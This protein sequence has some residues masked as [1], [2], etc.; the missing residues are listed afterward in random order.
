MRKRGYAIGYPFTLKVLRCVFRWST[1]SGVGILLLCLPFRNGPIYEI[2]AMKPYATP[3]L[4]LF[5]IAF[6]FCGTSYAVSVYQGFEYSVLEGDVTIEGYIFTEPET[7]ITIPQAIEGLPVTAIASN[8]FAS[9]FNLVAI[10][11]PEGVKS[12]GP[13]SFDFCKYLAEI[14]I[15]QTVTAIGNGAFAFCER[16]ESVSLP[17]GLT[18]IEVGLFDYCLRLQTVTVPEGVISIGNWAFAACQSL[19]TLTIPAAVTSI[20]N[21]AFIECPSLTS[22][23]F[24]G[25][26]PALGVDVFKDTSVQLKIYHLN[27]M[28]GW[29]V[30][31]GGIP[32]TTFQPANENPWSGFEIIEN[33]SG[34]WVNTGDWLGWLE[35][36]NSPWVWSENEQNF[37]YV[38]PQTSSNGSGWAYHP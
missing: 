9:E 5:I 29:G 6:L 11:I 34:R 18:V 30:Y 25:E 10:T 19:K 1:L 3:K 33:S 31:Y 15:S 8:A 38:P 26:P 35:I 32:T 22:L 36:G 24:Y 17:E 14:N 4:L 23:Y 28:P 12:I 7:R 21:E 20:G 16:L 37:I 27:D 13:H 2:L